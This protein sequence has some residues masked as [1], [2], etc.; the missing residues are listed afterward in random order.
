MWSTDEY[1]LDTLE[2]TT[3]LEII[4]NTPVLINYVPD[5][6]L[7]KMIKKF[8]KLEEEIIVKISEIEYS[9]T[10]YDKERFLLY[11]NDGNEVYITLTKVKELSNYTKIKKQLG[12]KKGILYLDKRI[13]IA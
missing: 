12:E 10:T 4:R 6:T 9:P 5:E 7:D 8:S 3:N 11:M 1:V 2:K 13:E